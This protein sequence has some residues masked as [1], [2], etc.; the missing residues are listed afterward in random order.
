MIVRENERTQLGRRI[1]L[2]WIGMKNGF[3]RFVSLSA[4]SFLSMTAVVSKY[5]RQNTG[6]CQQVVSINT[7]LTNVFKS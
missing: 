6:S 2:E 1:V 7:H 3:E 5:A 4:L